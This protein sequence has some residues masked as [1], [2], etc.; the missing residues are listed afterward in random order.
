MIE[1]LCRTTSRSAP[2]TLTP[3]LSAWR[4]AHR[5]PNNRN[6]TRI[7]SSVSNVRSLR[8]FRLAQM[9]GRYFMTLRAAMHCW[10]SPKIQ[11]PSSRE[12]QNQKVQ[13]PV[14]SSRLLPDVWNLSLGGFLVFGVWDL[15]LRSYDRRV[16]ELPFVQVNRARGPGGSMR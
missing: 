11:A 15:E 12:I 1:T 5:Y 3:A 8:R 10:Q 7:D 13:T 2:A 4:M 6:A 9:R 16:A 14:G